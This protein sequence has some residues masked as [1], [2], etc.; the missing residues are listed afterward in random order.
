MNKEKLSI[1]SMANRLDEIQVRMN[2]ITDRCEKESRTRTQAENTEFEALRREASILEAR[3]QAAGVSGGHRAE[4]DQAAAFD[5]FV[6]SVVGEGRRS[7]NVQTLRRDFTGQT[8]VNSAAAVPLTIGDIVQPLEKGLIYDKVGLPILTG[9]AGDYCWPVVG[10]VEAAIAGEGVALADSQ[11]DIDD[12]KP[13]PVRLGISVDVTN[14]TITQ[15][16]GV[17]AQI[18]QQQ[19]PLAA[20]RLINK[21]LFVTSTSAPG[22]NAKFHGPF[23][24]LDASH[25][26]SF[27]GDVPTYRELVNLRGIV[28]GEGVEN[29]GTGAYVMSAETAALLESTPRDAGSGLMM[30][31]DGKL[32]GFPVFTTSYMTGIGFGVWSMQPLGQFGDIR[33]IVDPFSKSGQDVTRFTLNADWSMTTL[34]KEAFALGTFA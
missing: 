34:R 2:E 3:V 1:R 16:Q 9:L 26:K 4:M 12:L 28:F 11:I 19:L 33:F 27:A 32:G 5:A 10:S 29:D 7:T 23:V 18:V 14:Q 17:V 24:G 31:E 25:V 21:A 6:R 30:I 15:T 20:A 22:Y 8:T 13:E